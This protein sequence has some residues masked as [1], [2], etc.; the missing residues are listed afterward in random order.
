MNHID[1]KAGLP[2]RG[3]WLGMALLLAGGLGITS[4]TSGQDKAAPRQEPV[5]GAQPAAAAVPQMT[6]RGTD[7]AV[8]GRRFTLEVI[9]AN[10]I[11]QAV[12]D[13]EF[14]AEL[15]GNLEQDSRARSHAEKISSIAAENVHIVRMAVTPTKKGPARVDIILSMKNGQRQQVQQIIPVF[16]AEDA[17]QQAERPAGAS[18]LSVSVT[19]PKD[20]FADRPAMFLIHVHNTGAQATKDNMELVVSYG[21][22]N[23]AGVN[24]QQNFGG[25]GFGG[26]EFGGRGR[27]LVVANPTNPV[28]E[29]KINIPSLGPNESRTVPVTLTAHRIGD[30]RLAIAADSQMIG[31]AGVNAKF[32]PNAT[33]HSLLPATFGS[34]APRL[35][36]SL[37][38]VPE[39]GLEDRVS[40]TMKADEAFE[41]IA[42]MMDKVNHANAKK[43]DAFVA[44]LLEK[45]PDMN[46]MPMAMGDSC[47]LTPERAN[48]FIS[49]L[50]QLR[51]AM[52]QSPGGNGLIT[53][54][55]NPGAV[56]AQ[57]S[58]DGKQVPVNAEKATSAR[59]GAMM[60]VLGPESV[61]MR[62]ELIKFLAAV[63]TTE[64]TQALA[65]LAIF[66]EEEQVRQSAIDALKNCK[67]KDY[68]D[69]LVNGLNYPWPA[70]AQNASDAIVKLKRNDLMPQL[71][72]MLERPDPR[73]PVTEEC[74]EGKQV[75]REVVKINH[76]RNC[77]LC[78]PPRSNDQNVP[79]IAPATFTDVEEV[80][81]LG[82]FNTPLLAQVP[83]PNQPLPVSPGNGGGYG[84]FSVPDT[85]I[86]FD[87]TYLRQDFSVML[88]VVDHQPWPQTQRFDFLVRTREITD[89]EAKAYRDLLR[90]A[91][92]GDLT[93]YQR[94]AVAA[95]RSMTGRDAEPT[96]PAWRK[97]LEQVKG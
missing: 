93:P 38:D 8:V 3:I 19:S 24:I 34:L 53:R 28:R 46:G 66:S 91:S 15:D 17:P 67:Q 74:C 33:V 5:V 14:V 26:R 51:N 71:V 39:V 1:K 72:N 90:Q 21:T 16:A 63:S 32:D 95:L 7:A 2:T 96:A 48:H 75:V 61:T 82:R 68:T 70:V 55:A 37:A 50:G 35:P 47:R 42:H 69:V 25:P 12:K 54:M 29:A 52:A 79:G 22:M 49:E 85:L 4:L 40:K 77:M 45:R 31:S 94:A 44:A 27:G 81:V 57:F 73:A 10:P 20:C 92:A 43:V 9:I 23:N 59:I 56:G 78:H 60:Q 83:I 30:F 13:L 62:Q 18:P 87:V 58:P 88:P 80:Q 6:I 36:K 89:Q 86:R 97:I 11:A 41:Q 65:K 76:L 64:S 84:Q